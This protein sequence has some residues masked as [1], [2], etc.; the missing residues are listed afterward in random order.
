MI[1]FRMLLLLLLSLGLEKVVADG[2]ENS[3]SC[4]NVVNEEDRHSSGTPQCESDAA[5]AMT[6]TVCMDQH[7]NCETW[8]DEGKCIEDPSYMQTHC[9]KA[10]GKCR[11]NK[12]SQTPSP[13]LASPYVEGNNRGYIEEPCEDEDELCSF[14]AEE[15]ECEENPNYM[16]SHCSKAC[17]TCRMSAP[18]TELYGERQFFSRTDDES[19]AHIEKNACIHD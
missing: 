4:L 15:G 3:Q 12:K 1:L 2:S 11:D 18:F 5:T 14:W 7:V 6:S 9:A 16:H 10:C 19:K 13:P 8:D 17:G